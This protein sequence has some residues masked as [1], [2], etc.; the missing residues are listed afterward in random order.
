VAPFLFGHGVYNYAFITLSFQQ[1]MSTNLCFMAVVPC[2]TQ[3]LKVNPP[4]D[5]CMCTKAEHLIF[6]SG[7]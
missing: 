7:G 1:H 4:G 5:H 3:W 6:S 2:T